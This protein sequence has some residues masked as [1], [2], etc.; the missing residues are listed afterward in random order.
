MHGIPAQVSVTNSNTAAHRVV[1]PA[2]QPQQCTLA[3][4][5]STYMYRA[6]TYKQPVSVSTDIEN[7]PSYATVARDAATKH[8]VH[9]QV[10][11][12]LL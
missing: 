10:T 5:A 7:K 3:P 6:Y 11:L 9:Q 8:G 4:S 12:C 2:H 1:E